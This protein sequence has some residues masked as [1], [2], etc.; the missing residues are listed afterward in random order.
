MEEVLLDG[1]VERF[2]VGVM[3]QQIRTIPDITDEDCE[4]LHQAMT[5]CS[6]W[7][8][9]NDQSAAAQQDTSEPDELEADIEKLNEWV[10]RIRKRRAN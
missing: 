9:G 2:G 10:K 4:E 5:K 7:L 3:T 6:K 8:P 1:V